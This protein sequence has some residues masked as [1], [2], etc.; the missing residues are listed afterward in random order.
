MCYSKLILIEPL[1]LDKLF[2]LAAIGIVQGSKYS[3]QVYQD[4][5]SKVQNALKLKKIYRV[6]EVVDIL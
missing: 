2:L 6:L 3:G 1:I 5:I 4:F